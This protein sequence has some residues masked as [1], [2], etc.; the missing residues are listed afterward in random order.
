MHHYTRYTQDLDRYIKYIDKWSRVGTPPINNP[1]K[2]IQAETD[3]YP[4]VAKFMYISEA[5][6]LDLLPMPEDGEFMVRAG[7]YSVVKDIIDDMGGPP[8]LVKG[9]SNKSI[10]VL[11]RYFGDTVGGSETSLKVHQAI[12]YA[13]HVRAFEMDGRRTYRVSPGLSDMLNNTI[14]KGLNCE[15]LRLPYMAIGV[16]APVV[17]QFKIWNNYS[18]WHN[19]EGAYLL[20]DSCSLPNTKNEY[21]GYDDIQS[22]IEPVRSLAVMLTGH[23]VEG[24]HPM[25][26]AVY[27]FSV[28][29][30]DGGKLEEQVELAAKTFSLNKGENTETDWRGIFRWLV[31]VVIYSTWPDCERE[32]VWVDSGAKKLWQR[33]QKAD[34]K[35]RSRIA[36]R[37]KDMDQTKVI[38][39]GGSVKLDRS[40][41]A[42]RGSGGKGT[43]LMVRQ[44]ISGHWKAQ[45]FGKKMAMRKLIWVEPYWRG[46]EDGP[47][48]LATT[49][50]LDSRATR[51]KD[52]L[53]GPSG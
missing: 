5:L 12:R 48:K 41:G 39:L 28:R 8:S 46:P 3:V 22:A 15:D 29:L 30:P 13:F 45:P 53:G 24:S 2:R 40:T 37:L 23:S 27:S 16:E 4:S 17:P 36:R 35:K 9:I 31:N 32:H 14:L 49:H 19:F 25:D 20:E 34:G 38:Y 52:E 47:I 42:S 43:P 1:L 7:L 10:G 6:K 26:D 50:T 21:R 18:G 11:Q 33:M 44:K 51:R